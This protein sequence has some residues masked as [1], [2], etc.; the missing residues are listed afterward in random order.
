M[1]R[2]LLGEVGAGK[3]RL[4]HK[5]PCRALSCIIPYVTT[6][7][8]RKD[9]AGALSGAAYLAKA[10]ATPLPTSPTQKT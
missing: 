10:L 8:R 6:C 4:K 1:D 7:S 5:C 9:T 3:L 2:L